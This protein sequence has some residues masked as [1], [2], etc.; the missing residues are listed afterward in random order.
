MAPFLSLT[1]QPPWKTPLSQPNRVINIGDRANPEGR[2][3]VFIAGYLVD[4]NSSLVEIGP[5]T[6][7]DITRIFSQ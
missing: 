4:T 3:P 1:L 5:S 2:R 7:Q 6:C